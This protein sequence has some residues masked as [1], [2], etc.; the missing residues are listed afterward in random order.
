MS[1][2]GLFYY[3]NVLVNPVSELGQIFPRKTVVPDVIIYPCPNVD[4]GLEPP[5]KC[6]HGWETTAY[7]KHLV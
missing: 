4:S 3:N 2:S 6:G 5:L 1:I 7:I